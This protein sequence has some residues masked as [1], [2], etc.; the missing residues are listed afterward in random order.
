[1]LLFRGFL[2]VGRI[3]GVGAHKVVELVA[4]ERDLVDQLCISNRFQQVAGG[5]QG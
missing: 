3:G 2:M 5:Y 4:V 1:M